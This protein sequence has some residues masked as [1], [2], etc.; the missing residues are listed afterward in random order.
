[1]CLNEQLRLC[2]GYCC[3]ISARETGNQRGY[4]ARITAIKKIL[5]GKSAALARELKQKLRRLSSK[6]EFE[7]AAAVRDELAGIDR[8]A[9]HRGLLLPFEK[10]DAAEPEANALLAL[11]QILNLKTFPYRIEC[12][13]A[14]SLAGTGA[15]GAMTVF[16]NNLPDTS[17]WRLF[18]MHGAV[19]PNDLSQIEEMLLRRLARRDWPMPDLMLVDGGSAQLAAAVRALARHK[20]KIP[21]AAIMKGKSARDRLLWNSGA[22]ALSFALLPKDVR[23]TLANIRDKTHYFALSYQRRIR[24]KSV[25]T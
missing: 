11:K 10:Q 12:Y 2:P 22:R 8:I 6:K 4:G 17:G 1:M 13:D 15:V 16:A 3:R 20:L 25:F 23:T 7:K 21:V 9:A 14:S 24:R 18:K 19:K 5:S